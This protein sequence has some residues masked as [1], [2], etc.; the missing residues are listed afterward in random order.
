MKSK[1]TEVAELESELLRLN[2]LVRYRRRQLDE[3]D[4]CPNAECECR[5]VWRH[6]VEST[7]AE[8]MG[9]IGKKVKPTARKRA[10][11]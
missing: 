5:R 9:K 2:A 8:Q 7:L 3:I 1:A 11:K 4:R 10:K 6:Q